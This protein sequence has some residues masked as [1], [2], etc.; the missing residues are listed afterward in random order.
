MMNWY[1]IMVFMIVC[2]CMVLDQL[3]LS[4][5]NRERIISEMANRIYRIQSKGVSNFTLD[6]C[7]E[8]PLNAGSLYSL[9]V[10]LLLIGVEINDFFTGTAE[11]VIECFGIKGNVLSG[12]YICEELPGFTKGYLFPPL[13]DRKTGRYD[14]GDSGNNQPL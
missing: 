3:N 14:W 1:S 7:R 13:G 5:E 6:H 9:I 10:E 2:E 11:M 12:N 8:L 4:P